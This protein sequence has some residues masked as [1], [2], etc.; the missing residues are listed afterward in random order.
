VVLLRFAVERVERL[1]R[2]EDFEELEELADLRRD[3]VP[4]FRRELLLLFFLSA[5]SLLLMRFRH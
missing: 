2:L 1:E 5:N 4:D 3:V